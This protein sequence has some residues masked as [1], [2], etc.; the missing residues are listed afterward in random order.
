VRK[1]K[2]GVV[3][4]EKMDKTRVVKV[5]WTSRHPLYGKIVRHSTKLYVHDDKNETHVGDK[6]EIIETRPISKTK[7]WAIIKRVEADKRG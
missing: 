5:N 1:I 2:T 6:V 3:I 7:R 4:S